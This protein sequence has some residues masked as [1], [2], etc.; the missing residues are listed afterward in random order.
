MI[1]P[2][3]VMNDGRTKFFLCL[4]RRLWECRLALHRRDPRH[5]YPSIAIP[6]A[7]SIHLSN[8]S[9]GLAPQRKHPV[10]RCACHQ[11]GHV[12]IES[13]LKHSAPRPQ[14]QAGGK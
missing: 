1:L 2:S 12:P 8:P 6:V 13:N 14:P 4:I 11:C 5:R 3:R 10:R 9:R 7:I